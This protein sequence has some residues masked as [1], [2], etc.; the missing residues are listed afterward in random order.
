MPSKGMMCVDRR[1]CIIYEPELL[2]LL[3]TL[4]IKDLEVYSGGRYDSI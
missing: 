4:G 3:R 1:T 2:L